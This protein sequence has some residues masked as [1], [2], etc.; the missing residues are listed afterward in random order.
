MSR[1]VTWW[2]NIVQ[3]MGK[4]DV[5]QSCF[6][7]EMSKTFVPPPTKTSRDQHTHGAPLKKNTT[8]FWGGRGANHFLEIS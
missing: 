4:R 5:F 1:D 8:S 7:E 3:G 6:L 2:H